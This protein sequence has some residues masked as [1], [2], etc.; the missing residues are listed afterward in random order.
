MNKNTIVFGILISLILPVIGY[1]IWVLIN[2]ILMSA[3]VTDKF[4]QI[5][6]FSSKT[7]VLVSICFNLIPFH[8][9]KNKRWDDMLRGCGLLTIIMLLS[10]AYYFNLFNI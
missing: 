6:Q 8:Y 5:F 7:M 10:W 9:A 3:N 1:A 2:Y 4:G